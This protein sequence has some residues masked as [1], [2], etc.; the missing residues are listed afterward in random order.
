MTANTTNKQPRGLRNCNP[1]NIRITPQQRRGENRW[2]GMCPMQQ[3]AGF[4]QF[5][6]MKWG[7]RAA[8]ILLTKTYYHLHSLYTIHDIVSRW[9]PPVD[10]NA[11]DVYIR[12]VCELTGKDEYDPIGI[13]SE[14]PADW[15]KLAVAMAIVE[16]G[17]EALDYF[18][19][20]DGWSLA[21]MEPVTARR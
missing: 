19:M 6:E 7:W 11:T 21:R 4:C 1:L 14:R 17:T 2:K 13:P 8:F 3:D 18:A 15:M 5:E 12:R 10:H 16:N 20:L 9:A